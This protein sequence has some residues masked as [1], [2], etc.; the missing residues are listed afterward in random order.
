MTFHLTTTNNGWLNVSSGVFSFAVS[1]ALDASPSARLFVNGAESSH[2]GG[3]ATVPLMAGMNT[4]RLSVT[5]HGG[6]V[7]NASLVVFVDAVTPT[8]IL[9]SETGSEMWYNTSPVPSLPRFS[10]DLPT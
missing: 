4:V 3:Q 5:D 9:T 2:A 1:D 10:Q 6:L 8:C 7:T